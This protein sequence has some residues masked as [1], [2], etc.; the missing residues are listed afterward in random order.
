MRKIIIATLAALN[1]GALT[2]FAAETLVKPSIVEKVQPVYPEQ[3]QQSGI[4]G[5]VIVECL[6]T[7]QGQVVGATAVKAPS[8]ELGDAAVAAVNQW[9]FQPAM[10]DGQPAEAVVRIPVEF[11]LEMNDDGTAVPSIIARN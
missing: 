8:P 9:K 6:I 10:R 2:I 11:R 7:S 1:L 5:R 4:E 3:C